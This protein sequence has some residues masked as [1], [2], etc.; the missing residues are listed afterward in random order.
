VKQLVFGSYNFEYGGLD[1]GSDLRLRRQLEMLDKV[2][3]DVWAFQECS[4]WQAERTRTLG[5]V[6]RE[7]QMRGYMARSNRGPGGDLAVFV[8]ESSRIHVIELRHEQ[9]P[10]WWHG[11]A[12]VIA[13]V[14]GYGLLRLASAHLAPSAPTLRVIEAE[15]FGLLCEQA[16]PLIAGGDWNAVPVADPV[17]DV[18]GIHPAK[19]RRK[20]DQRAAEAL[21]E[22]MT[23]VAGHLGDTTPT[24]GHRRADKLGYRCDRVYTTLPAESITGFEVIVEDEPESDHRPVVARLGLGG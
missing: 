14:E 17:P 11:V 23:D 7:L 16:T 21:A 20:L 8:R 24:V 4:H 19:S 1:D 22:Y 3:A 2:S 13:G 18:A 10:P 15:A 9:S 12:L 5:L 6:E